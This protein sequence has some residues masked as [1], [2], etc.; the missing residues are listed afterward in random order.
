[1]LPQNKRENKRVGRMRVKK[2]EKEMSML[3]SMVLQCVDSLRDYMGQKGLK[4]SDITA[5]KKILTAMR[6]SL[7]SS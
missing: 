2:K 4:Y 1:M 3:V 6:R 7:N 5:T